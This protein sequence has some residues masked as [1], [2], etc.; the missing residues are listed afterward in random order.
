MRFYFNH[1]SVSISAVGMLTAWLTAST[2]AP[3]TTREDSVLSLQPTEV[4]VT[5]DL[6]YRW[7]EPQ[8]AVNPK[9]PN[10]IVYAVLASSY[11]YACQKT[12]SPE[13][14][15]TIVPG[16]PAM[17]NTPDKMYTTPNWMFSRYH[18]SFDRGRTWKKSA[19]ISMPD[20]PA[21]SGKAG[22][23]YNGDPNVR[24]TKDGTLW[25][26]F[27]PAHLEGFPYNGK[28]GNAACVAVAKSTD[29]GRTWGKATC[30]G[31]P[32]DRGFIEIDRSTGMLYIASTGTPGPTG[33]G[34]LNTPFGTVTD[35]WLTS[36]KDGVNWSPM[37][38]MGG[39]DGKTY[40]MG[41][42]RMVALNGVLATLS[43]SND[44]AACEFFV[45]GGAPC[46]VFQTTTDG[47]AHWTRHRILGAN[48]AGGPMA[49]FSAMITANASAPGHYSVATSGA[50]GFQVFRTTDSGATWSAPATVPATAQFK[51]AMASSPNGKIGIIW[52]SRLPD[53][54]YNVWGAI[55]D[56][57]GATFSTPLQISR[58]NSPKED[59][60]DIMDDFS[61]ITI[62]DRYAYFAWGDYRPGDRQGY[63][64]EVPL[65]TF[66]HK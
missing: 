44:A 64:S 12:Q 47:G 34:D 36:S 1:R 45:G 51:A 49:G 52:R 33:T 62:T 5:N 32:V 66:R 17:A 31:T 54:G 39:T 21:F 13:C 58:G 57:E 41:G 10:N 4:N 25:I 26:T 53:G 16:R 19:E 48:A 3:A 7:G 28:P 59:S 29:G 60:F 35:R 46:F 27:Q 38:G 23:V 43:V 42:A 30:A 22:A 24:V 14:V 61:D 15:R 63:F 40:H 50:G 9:N 6:A 18:V 55:S 11:T 65:D 20:M 2:T 56:D 8:I 37:K